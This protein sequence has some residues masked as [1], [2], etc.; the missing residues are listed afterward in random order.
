MTPYEEAAQRLYSGYYNNGIRSEAN[1]GGFAGDG[2]EVN[3]KA[4]LADVGLVVSAVALAV[5]LLPAGAPNAAAALRAAEDAQ[6]WY[7][8]TKAQ[9]E[10]FRPVSVAEL[11][12]GLDNTKFL[13][14]LGLFSSA[15]SRPLAWSPTLLLSR[16]DGLSRDVTLLGHTTLPSPTDF[17]KGQA[18]RIRLGIGGVGGWTLSTGLAWKFPLGQHELSGAPGQVDSLTYY[19]HAPNDIEA[20]LIRGFSA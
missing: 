16:R 9:A 20:V 4:A 14:A 7:L 3:F 11:W 12:E 15:E 17:I 1:P 2:H 19:V 8:A 5:T 18:G 10:F 13:S 6:E